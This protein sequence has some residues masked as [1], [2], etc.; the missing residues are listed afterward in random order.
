MNNKGQ[1]TV[2]YMLLLSLII[3]ILLFSAKTIMDETEKNTILTS[4]QIGAQIGVDKNAYA[5]YYNDTFNNYQDN[6]P[7]LLHPT[8]IKVIMINMTENG[9]QLQLQA[10][11]HANAY[12]NSNEKNVIS[13]R[14]NYYIRRSISEAFETKSN[15]L[16]YDNLQI[17]NYKINTK[18]VKWV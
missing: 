6:Y 15:D 3:L 11:L 18:I 7:K 13:S 2:E 12:L 1:I 14:V 10:V 16:Y 9:N 8:E 5:M 17:K 4:A